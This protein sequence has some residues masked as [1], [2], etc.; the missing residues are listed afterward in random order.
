LCLRRKVR[1]RRIDEGE[2]KE[3]SKAISLT[4]PS[5]KAKIVCTIV[6]NTIYKIRQ[7]IENI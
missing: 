1:E 6:H 3:T 5:F 7:R 2:L 4:T